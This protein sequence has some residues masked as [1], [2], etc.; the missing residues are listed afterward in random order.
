MIG[1]IIVGVLFIT[2][3]VGLIKS[4]Q[5]WT[6][7]TITALALIFV[8]SVFGGITVSRTLKTRSAWIIKD[9]LNQ[10]LAE[11]AHAAYLE[12]LN[13][14]PDAI[15]F[16]PDSHYGL[17]N[18]VNLMAIGQG[19]IWRSG[20]PVVEGDS[21]KVTFTQTAADGTTGL[22][23]QLKQDMT[24]YVFSDRSTT[25]ANE[26][27]TVPV[28]YVGSYQVT[29]VD[30]T[31]NSLVAKPLFVTPLSKDEAANP[32]SSWTLFEKMPGDSR[33]VF[34][35]EMGITKYDETQIS[36]YRNALRDKYLTAESVGLDPASKEYEALL[37]EYTFDGLPMN[38]ITKWIGAQP[39][40]INENFDPV[41]MFR[42]ARV[43]SNVKQEYKVDGNGNPVSVGPFDQQGL[44][45]DPALHLNRDA[46]V[47]KD[48]ELIISK[49]TMT[50]FTRVDGNQ[51]LGLTGYEEIVDYYYRP[52]RDYPYS[53]QEYGEQSIRLNEAI[54]A[55]NADIAITREVIENTEAQ[56]N[57]RADTILKLQSDI[58]R[59]EQEL[60]RIT[61]H[62]A[63][64]EREVA[65]RKNEI[66]TVYGQ[67]MELYKNLKSRSPDQETRIETFDDSAIVGQK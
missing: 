34:L 65:R 12:V 22:A 11:K 10:D 66:Q 35:D 21:I 2:L 30:A 40:R 5:N 61:D 38:E 36:A 28:Q 32:T 63:D 26:Q 48:Q 41:S 31:G 18:K 56:I 17:N 60:V 29:S 6:W 8:T 51:E 44:A 64:L 62:G 54:V 24:V 33:S 49:D 57:R 47:E 43:K 7:V 46:V 19:R 27:V 1:W 52:M 59:R 55:I 4:A 14:S 67:I 45:N 58:G 3:V 16:P 20:Q 50:G 53:M 39:D 15:T 23:A 13:G 37:D 9:R 25:I 42:A